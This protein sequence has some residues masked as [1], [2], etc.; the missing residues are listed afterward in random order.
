MS[1]AQIETSTPSEVTEAF[2]DAEFAQQQAEETS[3]TA[4]PSAASSGFARPTRPGRKR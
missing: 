1:G 4:T 3:R 2:V